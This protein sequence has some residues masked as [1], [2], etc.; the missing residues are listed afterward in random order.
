MAAMPVPVAVHQLMAALV[1][2]TCGMLEE[3]PSRG[4]ALKLSNV[5][6]ASKAFIDI[7]WCYHP[8]LRNA[9]SASL[10]RISMGRP[11][12]VAERSTEPL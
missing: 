2:R 7:G 9:S 3:H 6:N 4:S 10:Q 1:C 11:R 5:V 8:A 12:H